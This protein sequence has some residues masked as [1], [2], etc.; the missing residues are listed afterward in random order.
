LVVKIAPVQFL[1]YLT[2]KC[3]ISTVPTAHP[4]PLGVEGH[5]DT[6]SHA[7]QVICEF[8]RLLKDTNDVH[9]LWR[10]AV[11]VIAKMF[12]VHLRTIRRV[13]ARAIKSYS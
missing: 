8:W 2:S 12:H 4:D 11:T 7:K 10:G 5:E 3:T 1:S 6:A 13:L 9:Y